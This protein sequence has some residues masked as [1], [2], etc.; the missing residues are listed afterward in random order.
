MARILLAAALL[1]AR[2]FVVCTCLRPGGLQPRRQP[3]TSTLVLAGEDQEPLVL[4]GLALALDRRNRPPFVD[5]ARRKMQLPFAVQLMRQSYAAVEKLKFVATDEFQKSFFLFRQNE[6]DWWKD[7]YPTLMQGELND[8]LYFDHVSFAQYAVI[9]DKMRRGKQSYIQLIDANGTA[10]SVQRD[11]SLE[12]NDLLPQ[13]HSKAVGDALLDWMLETYPTITP[14]DLP[15]SNDTRLAVQGRPRAPLSEFVPQAQQ[16]LDIFEL[17]S[18]ALNMRVEPLPVAASSSSSS[19][20]PP[21]LF[22][23]TLTGPANLWSSQ[24]L[25]RRGDE[26]CNDFELKVLTSLA[27]RLGWK[28]V[29]RTATSVAGQANVLH[30]CR[31]V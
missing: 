29:E 27:W 7:H 15:F 5:F 23:V 8:P 3:A 4:K 31:L 18:Y 30:V 19:S 16:L 25:R 26:P 24:T 6:W 28:G 2:L 1:A 22:S 10:Q 12:N 11:K 21:T 13:A 14:R 9:A 20:A 17:N